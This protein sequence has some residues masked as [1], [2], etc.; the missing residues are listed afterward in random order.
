MLET[1]REFGLERLVASAEEDGVRRAHAAC[2]LGLAD[3]AGWQGSNETAWFDR[4]EAEL[5]NLRAALAWSCAGGSPDT[6][7][8]LAARFGRFCFRRGQ[9]HL[10]GREWLDRALAVAP[11]TDPALRSAALSARG[12]L[13]RELGEPGEAE[14]SFTLGRELSRT[15]GDRAGEATA[16]TGLSALANDRAEYV[17]QKALCEASAAIWRELGDHRGLA[18]AL[19]NQAWAE[20]GLGNMAIATTLLEE[21]LDHARIS[22]DHRWIARALDGLGSLFIEQGNFAAAR[23]LAEEGLATARAAHDRQEVAFITS[24]LGMLSLE[25]GDT[26]SARAYLAEC[27]TLLRDSGR[28]RQVVFAIEGCAVLAASQRQEERAVRLVAAAAAMRVEMDLPIERDPRW[29]GVIAAGHSTTI[30]P[31]LLRLVSAAANVDRVMSMDEA[32]QDAIALASPP[33]VPESTVTRA[34]EPNDAAARYGLTSREIDVLRLV[35]AGRS[36]RA[37]ADALFISHRTASK[38]VS[39]ILAKLDAISRSEVAARAVR[40]G[41]I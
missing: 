36:D 30:V 1:I 5:A 4:L 24:D 2:Y 14:R 27:L 33:T 11:D 9:H 22:G 7:L 16:L 18:H 29:S 37:I 25:L 31:T 34:V 10:E 19:H 15:T 40:D 17:A 41:L 28:R 39:S 6:A 3:Q 21:T 35:V 26:A 20:V 23:P 32:I 13:L 8:R 38:H 12:D